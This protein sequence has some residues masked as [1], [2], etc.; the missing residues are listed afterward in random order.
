MDQMIF[1]RNEFEGE[2]LEKNRPK[3]DKEEKWIC[4]L[5]SGLIGLALLLALVFICT[6]FTDRSE[7]QA[8]C[9]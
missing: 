8:Y 6:D 5:R 1:Y 7:P 4:F 9:E 3:S 2:R